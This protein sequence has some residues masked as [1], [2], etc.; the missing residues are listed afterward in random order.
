[1]QRIAW[2]IADQPPH[3]DIRSMISMRA[4]ILITALLLTVRL[5][6]QT[7]DCSTTFEWMVS[8]FE[9]NDAGFRL[10]LDRKGDAAYTE[11]TEA[12]RKRADD[13]KDLM[14]CTELLNGWL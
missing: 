14:A 13:A 7:C 5:C 9:Q 6:A 8:T 4:P 12:F 10:V 2:N 11:H 3:C 1:L